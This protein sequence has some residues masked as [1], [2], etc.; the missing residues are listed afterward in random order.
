PGSWNAWDSF[1]EGLLALADTVAARDA[2][3]RSLALNPLNAGA[4]A[5]LLATAV[6]TPRRAS[7]PRR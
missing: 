1:G 6:R 4:R 7:S 2:Y 3:A 5:A